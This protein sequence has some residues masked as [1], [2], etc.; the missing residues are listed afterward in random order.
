MAADGSGSS[1][2]TVTPIPTATI[3][4]TSRTLVRARPTSPRQKTSRLRTAHFS[5]P[6]IA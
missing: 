5:R 4:T 1:V 6:K 2:E 3:S